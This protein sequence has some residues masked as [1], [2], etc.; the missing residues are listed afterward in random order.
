MNPQAHMC[1]NRQC[2][3][4]G[5]RGTGQIVIHSRAVTV[6]LLC[7]DGFASY[8]T[9]ALRVFRQAVRTGQRGRPQMRVKTSA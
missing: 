1:H 5:Q 9:Q 6:L 4:Y 3:V 8:P 2:W 7:S